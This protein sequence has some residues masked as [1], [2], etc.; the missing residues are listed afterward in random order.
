LA[1]T[2][3]VSLSWRACVERNRARES[4]CCVRVARDVFEALRRIDQCGKVDGEV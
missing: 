1:G 4:R 3:A 2:E